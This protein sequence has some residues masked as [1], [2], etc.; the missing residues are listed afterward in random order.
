MMTVTIESGELLKWN[1]KFAIHFV[2]VMFAEQMPLTVVG[3]AGF[4]G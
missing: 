4:V 3:L 2:D 1:Y